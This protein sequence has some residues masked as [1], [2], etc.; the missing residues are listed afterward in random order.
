LGEAQASPFFDLMLS[1]LL[2]LRRQEAIAAL[3]DKAAFL[4][5]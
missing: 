4:K 3:S 1:P 2:F 5:Q